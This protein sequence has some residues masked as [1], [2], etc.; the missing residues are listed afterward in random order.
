MIMKV[1]LCHLTLI[2]L[3]ELSSLPMWVS[4]FFSERKF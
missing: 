4:L 1:M 3:G 2:L